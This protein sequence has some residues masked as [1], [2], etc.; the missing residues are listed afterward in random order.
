MDQITT[1][2][3][4]AGANVPYGF[5]TAAGLRHS[6]IGNEQFS[7]FMHEMPLELQ[8]QLNRYQEYREIFEK[9]SLSSIDNHLTKN[10]QYLE[11]GKYCIA[12]SLLT[13]ESSSRFR[14]KSN[15]PKED[16][17]SFLFNVLN[18]G[19]ET[20]DDFV[21]NCNNLNVITFNYD[22]SFEMFFLESIWHT[23]TKE[24]PVDKRSV[25][26]IPFTIHHVYGSLG[27]LQLVN[28]SISNYGTVNPE[29]RISRAIQEIK[30]IDE[31]REYD[32]DAFSLIDTADDVFFLGF[33]FDDQ[34]LERLG[35]DSKTLNGVNVY[36][37]IYSQKKNDINRIRNL[38]RG[39]TSLHHTK[40]CLELLENHFNPNSEPNFWLEVESF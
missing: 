11:I 35:L 19:T 23:F 26:D 27:D 13:Y 4:G 8:S 22:R 28:G 36:A 9:S 39:S 17:Y 16:W 32:H 2:V 31:D 1:L 14:E 3:V 40:T 12:G 6:I 33:G 30:I 34:N 38:F 29:Y 18:K 21:E 5:P 20:F 7:D 24:F 10:P 15:Y 25:E 37:S